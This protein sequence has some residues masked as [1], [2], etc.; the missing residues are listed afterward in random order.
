MLEN[1]RYDINGL[2][3]FAYCDNN[4][5]AGRDDEGNMSFWKKLAI[6]AAVVVAVAVVA[7]VVA[8]ATAATGGAAGAALCAV[9]STFVGAAKG[10]VIGAVT[11]ALTGAAT[12]AVQGA[13]E[14]YKETG[15]LE[16]TLRGMG[17]GAA[18]GAV[19]GAQDGLLSGMVMGGI[20]GAMNPSFCFVAGTT[21]LTTL[22][23]KAIETVQVGDTIPCVD[24]ITG[25]AT[26]KKVISTTVNK[27]NRLIELDIDGEIIQCTETHPFQVKDKGWIDACNLNPKDIVYTKDWGTATVQSVD[28]LELDEPVEVFNFEVEDYHT[29]FI[30]ELNVLVHNTCP[31]KDYYRG[32]NDF[33]AKPSD[34]KVNNNGM[35][36]TTHGVSVNTNPN[37]VAQHGV[38]HKIV[39]LPDGLDIIQRGV[40]I[41]HYEIV[42]SQP[43]PLSQYQDLLSQIVSVAF[44]G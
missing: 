27:V 10:A 8:A 23:K 21:V 38:P 30:S 4:P 13:V 18:K 19:Q 22:G 2:N 39:D 9:T 25:E 29:Y 34:I 24:H 32:G 43:M 28:L 31:N 3:L 1:A 42:P 6:A 26:E 17:K 15:T 12:G 41:S 7:A 33:S 16:G 20:S 14:G 11:G 35:V 36:K 44:G 37:A 5:V 40:N